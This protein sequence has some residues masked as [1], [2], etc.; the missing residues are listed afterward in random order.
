MSS[1]HEELDCRLCYSPCCEPISPRRQKTTPPVPQPEPE[2]EPELE[3][4]V[5]IT[6]EILIEQ[7]ARVCDRD[8]WHT[9]EGL[10]SDDLLQVKF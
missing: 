2:P 4:P 8:R 3:E 10:N 9:T 5:E 7:L 6:L 1:K